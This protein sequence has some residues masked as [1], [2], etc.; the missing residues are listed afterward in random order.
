VLLLRDRVPVCRRHART[1][2]Y[3]Q[4]RLLRRLQVCWR[5]A[6]RGGAGR[7]SACGRAWVHA[8]ALQRACR[9]RSAWARR[10][11]PV[12]PATGLQGA[13]LRPA[14]AAALT[15]CGEA[16][17][18]LARCL[19]RERKL[20]RVL[21]LCLADEAA[22]GVCYLR[23]R[24]MQAWCAC[25]RAIS[26]GTGCRACLQACRRQRDRSSTHAHASCASTHACGRA[27]PRCEVTGRA[28]PHIQVDRRRGV[29]LVDRLVV[30]H[31]DHVG[32]QLLE[33]ALCLGLHLKV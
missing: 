32:V 30:A 16:R 7:G 5:K 24:S 10:H 28:H 21:L 22:S 13:G 17:L 29:G 8:A 19:G 2:V 31:H 33:N 20:P 25:V 9:P 11:A 15:V 27:V 23:V 4:L 3:R 6:Q 26:L 12:P 1:P 18:V 14:C